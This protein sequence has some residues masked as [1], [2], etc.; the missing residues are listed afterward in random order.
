MSKLFL[1]ITSENDIAG[2]TYSINNNTHVIN[3]SH[4]TWNGLPEFTQNSNVSKLLDQNNTISCYKC[5]ICIPTINKK[6]IIGN[7][8]LFNNSVHKDIWFNIR[9]IKHHNFKYKDHNIYSYNCHFKYISRNEINSFY[10]SINEKTEILD[11]AKSVINFGRSLH[12]YN[13]TSYFKCD[14]ST[15]YKGIIFVQ[16]NDIANTIPYSYLESTLIKKLQY[17]LDISNIPKDEIEI[18]SNIIFNRLLGIS[19]IN[20]RKSKQFLNK[21]ILDFVITRSKSEIDKRRIDNENFTPFKSCAIDIFNINRKVYTI[22]NT[23][24][25]T[26]NQNDVL[27]V[28]GNKE[29][30]SQNYYNEIDRINKEIVIGTKSIVEHCA[31]KI[32]DPTNE[33]T[34]N[35][36][37]I[38]YKDKRSKKR[39]SIDVYNILMSVEP[40][41]YKLENEFSLFKHEFIYLYGKNEYYNF[42]AS[43]YDIV[44]TPI[45]KSVSNNKIG[46]E[47]KKLSVISH[48]DNSDLIEI[49]SNLSQ[50]LVPNRTL[51]LTNSS[52][53]YNLFLQII[54]IDS[55][56]LSTLIN[57]INLNY[58]SSYKYKDLIDP[59][60]IVSTIPNLIATDIIRFIETDKTICRNEVKYN[61]KIINEYLSVMYHWSYLISDLN[62]FRYIPDNKFIIP[63][64]EIQILNIS[65]KLMKLNPERIIS[66]VKN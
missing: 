61:S 21:S 43:I 63:N 54:N 27:L 6:C 30:T 50:Y 28:I 41:D 18:F 7:D 5:N 38:S 39:I 23:I 22:L 46:Q 45:F 35:M 34:I 42:I 52:Y 57:I 33:D 11:I 1:D 14:L 9:N 25:N 17:I 3:I 49:N 55:F 60:N 20:S 8:N 62:K 44:L 29:Y 24:S 4:A 40:N 26:L 56:N 19:D 65:K 12:K 64:T 36:F 66:L 59:T 48:T 15:N 2:K 16:N 32:F 13:D 51:K 58:Y 53:N 10:N 31:F 47:I 37:S